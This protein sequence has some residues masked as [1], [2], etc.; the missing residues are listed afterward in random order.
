MGEPGRSRPPGGPAPDGGGMSPLAR[1]LIAILV[2]A[3][4]GLAIGL[5][6]A[7]GGSDDEQATTATTTQTTTSAPTTTTTQTTTTQTTTTTGT[8]TDGESGGTPAP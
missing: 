6:V 8:V 3:V 5:V 1:A 7:T 2:V 4:I